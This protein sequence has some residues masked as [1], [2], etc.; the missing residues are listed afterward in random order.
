[1]TK[2]QFFEAFVAA[3]RNQGETS[4]VTD[5]DRHHRSFAE[6]VQILKAARETQRP[7]AKALPRALIGDEITGRFPELDYA[8]ASLQFPKYVGAKNP[9]YRR[10]DLSLDRDT[11]KQILDLYPADQRELISEM[12]K[13]FAEQG[14]AVG[15]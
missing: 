6:A 8:L 3:L 14:A 13:V 15:S 1:M 9:T 11:A 10:V 12:A 7:G 2:Q 5:G 4:V